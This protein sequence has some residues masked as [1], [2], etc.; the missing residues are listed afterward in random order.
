MIPSVLEIQGPLIAAVPLVFDS[1]HSGTSYPPDFDCVLAKEQLR[2]AEDTHVQDLFG[3]AGE[4]GAPLLHALFPRSY[5][6]PNRSEWDL[7][8]EIIDGKWPS[9]LSPS[10]KALLGI[11]LIWSEVRSKGSIYDR[12]LSVAEVQNRIE[13]YW[14]PYHQALGAIIEATH[15]KFGFVLHVNLHSMRSR[16]IDTDPDGPFE[17][18]DFVVGDRNHTSCSVVLTEQIVGALKDL[19]YTVAVNFPY[20]GQV[21]ISRFSAPAANKHSVQIEVNRSLYMDEQTREKHGG[22]QV[23]RNNMNCFIENLAGL[24]G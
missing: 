15:E 13:N 11:G 5:I 19:G 9:A 21:L 10:S 6:D 18:P 2:F 4:I 16:G 14:R 12:K 24:V 22:Y 8:P 3:H 23:L 17:R 7:D 20:S 1:P